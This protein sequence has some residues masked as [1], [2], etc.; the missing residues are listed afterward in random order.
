L[1]EWFRDGWERH[2]GLVRAAYE[3]GVTVLAGTDLPPGHLSEEV[4]WLAEAGLPAEV[5]LS[6]ASWNARRFLGLP[7]IDE[8]QLPT[9]GEP[10]ELGN[11]VQTITLQRHR[12]P[13]AGK[14]RKTNFRQRAVAPRRGLTK[15]ATIVVAASLGVRHLSAIA[16]PIRPGRTGVSTTTAYFLPSDWQTLRH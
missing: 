8:G 3:A 11:R 12:Y 16:S 13:T 2:P 5:A 14:T 9:S 1:Q 7:S 15:R 6:A 4:R 10:A